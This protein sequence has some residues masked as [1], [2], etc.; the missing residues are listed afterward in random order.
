MLREFVVGG[1]QKLL[2]PFL[3]RGLRNLA[4]TGEWFAWLAG[5]NC[6][7]SRQSVEYKQPHT[8]GDLRPLP[9]TMWLPISE[10]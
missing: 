10:W 5:N 2:W 9:G 8:L 1:G 4:G 6:L 7:K 3:R